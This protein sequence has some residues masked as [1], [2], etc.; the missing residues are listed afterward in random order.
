[1]GDH[2]FPD[3][4]S[5]IN[6]NH[7]LLASYIG[8]SVH[9]ART[10]IINHYHKSFR[11]FSALL[12]PEQANE[13][14]RHDSV[15]SVFENQMLELHTTRSWD[16]LSEQEANNFGNGKFKG[17]FNHFRDN[18][19]A[20]MVIG[21]LDSGIWSESL[22][23]DPTGLSDASHSSFRGVCVIKGED[24]IPPPRCNNK[25]VG[26]RYYYKG[27][28]SSYGQ[29][30]DV[31]YSPRDDYG[32]G[33]HTIA[34]AAGRDVSFNMFGE[35]P[36]KGGAPKA[37][38]AVYKVCWHNTCACADV[39]GGFD[40]AINDGVNII[41]MSVGGNSA[42]GSSVFEDCMSLGALHAYR[43]GILVVTSGGNN[44]AK[45]R[46]TVQNPAPWVLTVAATSSDRRYMTDIIL[47]NGQVIK[48]FGLIPTDFSD[49][50]LTWQ[51]R[52]MN[53]AG[54]C[55]KNEVDPNYVQGKIVVCYILDGVDYGEVAGAVIQNTG[56][57]GM[58][59]VDPLE[60]GKMV[61]DFP[62]PG[63]VIVLRDYPILANYINFNNM[64]TVSFSRTT[65]MIHT[66]SAPTLAAFSGRG[67]NPV[68]PDIIK[69]D[70]AAPGVTIMSA[71]MGS[72]YLNAYTNK[73]MI[74]S[75]L[76]RFGAMSG[77]SMACPHV[78]GVATVLRSIIPNVSPDWLKSALMT[79]A[80]T[81]DNAGN[82][83]KAG[84]NPATPFDI[85]AGNIVPDLVF[86][87]GL[88]Y[89]VTNENFI[90]FLCTQGNAYFGSDDLKDKLTLILREEIRCKQVD[91]PSYNLNHPSIAV[92]GLRRGP[93]TVKRT[94]TIANTDSKIFSIVVGMPNSVS[95]K[96]STPVLDYT[97]GSSSKDFYLQFENINATSNVYG[98][99]AWTDNSTFY[100]KS[101]IALI[102]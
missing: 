72:M 81:I 24:N 30:G 5:V 40:D 27:Y 99:I 52:M 25:I 26:T 34:T 16:F 66:A 12:S 84:R 4:E 91:V 13:I 85:G 39:L 54:D 31:T 90:D 87:P 60:N 75:K 94:A 51:N 35:S 38:I 74:Q 69:P 42:V 57:T 59:F 65:T 20:D 21:T 36:I 63:P 58:I 10:K 55:Y 67:P 18:P 46:F 83:I 61:F 14:S 44:G 89:E 6:A 17:R 37:R 77:T 100:V 41:T 8:G 50:V 97:D 92:N 49:G 88:V 3:S 53:S 48:G 43:R 9:H 78:S 11:G 95:V 86:N 96:A 1:M 79:T 7:E 76:A 45:G 93:V 23:F 33:T 32:H 73:I 82:P 47:G 22:S 98:F 101:P 64:P 28:L 102:I 2:S 68:I 71:Y 19:M 29:L 70:I 15:V 62:K 56:A 80:T